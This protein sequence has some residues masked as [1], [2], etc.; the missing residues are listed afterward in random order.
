MKAN[1]FSTTTNFSI[2]IQITLREEEKQY[3][4]I[5]QRKK[6]RTQKTYT[7]RN[8]VMCIYMHIP[9]IL[10]LICKYITINSQ[11]LNYH[12]CKLGKINPGRN[13]YSGINQLKNLNPNNQTMK[14]PY[15]IQLVV[16]SLI[17]DQSIL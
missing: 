12:C 16:I 14:R 2:K 9:K 4:C 5:F 6:F 15:L 8:K 1:V 17:L 7:I 3:I 10:S 11:N 13:P